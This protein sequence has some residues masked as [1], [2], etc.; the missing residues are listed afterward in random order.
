[1]D[2]TFEWDTRKAQE[3]VNK[4]GVSFDEAGRVFTDPIS[5]ITG[6]PDHSED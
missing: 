1:M 3:N 4:H 5:I 6:D 2:F